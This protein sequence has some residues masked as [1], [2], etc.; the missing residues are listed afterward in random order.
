VAEG[1]GL[2]VLLRAFSNLGIMERK[3][4]NLVMIGG[5]GY[6]DTERNTY[7]EKLQRLAVTLGIS[8]RITWTGYC[9]P[10]EVSAYLQASDFCVLPFPNGV[11]TKRTSFMTAMAHGL[12]VITTHKGTLPTSLENL[13]NVLCFSPND[14]EGL[15]A[16]MQSLIGSKMLREKLAR[17][18]KKWS[19]QFPWSKIAERTMEVYNSLLSDSKYK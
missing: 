9:S 11:S 13:R 1:K 16:A 15:T 5:L 18:A 8:E 4:C 7:L 6:A 19:E 10:T 14:V 2:D 12:P 3:R 17:E